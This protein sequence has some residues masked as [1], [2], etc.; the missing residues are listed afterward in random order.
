M[1]HCSP[2]TLATYR[3]WMLKLQSFVRSKPAGELDGEDA[4]AFLMDLAVRQGVA[5][6]TRNHAFNALL[7]FYRHV[8]RRELGKLDGV[9]PAREGGRTP[10]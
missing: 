9:V 10:L 3:L 5:A 2:K 4:K 8:L 1:R 7:F 6:S